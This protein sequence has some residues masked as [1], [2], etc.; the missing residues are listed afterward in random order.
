MQD[1][2]IERRNQEPTIVVQVPGA[3]D[4][5][6]TRFELGALNEMRNE[7]SG[8]ISTLS[9]RKNS[10]Q[11]QWHRA[12]PAD[13]GAL[14]LRMESADEQIVALE[15]QLDGINARIASASPT[16]MIASTAPASSPAADRFV[17]SLADDLV[18]LVAIISVF[19]LAPLAV[20]ISRFIWKRAGAPPKAA[21]A[22]Q[23]AMQRLDQLQR[24]MDT[25]AIEVERISEGQRFVSKLLND[26]NA[27]ALPVSAQ[28]IPARSGVEQR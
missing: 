4:V 13:R 18:P 23:A 16:A 1:R 3:P 21:L 20:A 15:R 24:A 26:R 14:E 6:R 19:F 11:E 9:G 27:A 8:Q 12:G 25:V 17:R 22:D 5:P 7:I 28:A 2:R 10:L